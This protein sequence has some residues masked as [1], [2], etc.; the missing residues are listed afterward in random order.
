MHANDIHFKEHIDLPVTVSTVSTGQSTSD[1]SM[2]LTATGGVA[3]S[4][5]STTYGGLEP[6]PDPVSPDPV[7][8]PEDEPSPEDE[9]RDEE[10]PG[11]AELSGPETTTI[12]L[13]PRSPRP[14]PLEPGSPLPPIRTVETPQRPEQPP[15]APRTPRA[16]DSD[17]DDVLL[18]DLQFGTH[19]HCSMHTCFLCWAVHQPFE[20]W[21]NHTHASLVQYWANVFGVPEPILYT[22]ACSGGVLGCNCPCCCNRAFTRWTEANIRDTLDFQGNIE[23][24]FVGPLPRLPGEQA[25]SPTWAQPEPR[26]AAEFVRI[27]QQHIAPDPG[28]VTEAVDA[29]LTMAVDVFVRRVRRRHFGQFG[30]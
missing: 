6:H 20:V 5:D 21:R 15:R 25:G 13:A 10:D 14:A 17:S 1:T 7:S 27:A 16:G 30:L 22:T 28:P 26:H 23:R 24:A 9:E 29:D 18:A 3:D 19:Q 11:E 4:F 12:E 8:D 2:V